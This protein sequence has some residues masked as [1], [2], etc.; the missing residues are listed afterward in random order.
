M[1]A[2]LQHLQ[3]APPSVTVCSTTIHESMWKG[4]ADFAPNIDGAYAFE[5][6]LNALDENQLVLWFKHQLVSYVLPELEL[7]H[8]PGVG[9]YAKPAH[10]YHTPS[11][12]NEAITYAIEH[13]IREGYYEELFH[14]DHR[15][16]ITNAFVKMKDTFWAGTTILKARILGDFRPLN[17]WLL[18]PPHHWAWPRRIKFL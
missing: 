15:H 17:F 4:P 6:Y 2:I 16:W 18:P 14:V 9:P 7:Q 3:I 1:H 8:R 10:S 13:N 12:L 11:K 5:Q